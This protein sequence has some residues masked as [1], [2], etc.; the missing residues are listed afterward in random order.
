M[1]ILILGGDGMLGH[2]LL[3]SWQERHEVRVTLRGESAAYH[4][5][6][7]FDE[8]N[9]CFGVDVRDIASVEEALK[10]FA[11]EVVVN[12]VGIVK[13]RSEAADAVLSIEVNALFPHRLAQLCEAHR[14]RL[15]HMSTDCVFSGRKGMYKEGDL[16]DARDLYG[17]SKLLGELHYSHTLTLRTSIIG[18][19]LARKKSLIE[20]F[21]AQHGTVK[22]FARAIYSGFTTL[23]MARIIERLLL[24]W[25]GMNGLWHVA[26]QPISKYDLLVGLQRRLQLPVRVERDETFVCDRSLDAGRFN[27]HVG[28]EPPSWDAMLD[29]L[30]RQIEER[31][32]DS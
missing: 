7:L 21:L 4:G 32:H 1:R 26:S 28:Y 2:Q 10:A 23:E 5:Y 8:R 17:R 18:L 9:S 14:C 3:Q 24:E 19:E 30:A 31:A 29:E 27:A 12:A 22:G 6:R 11:P 13:Q 15:V 16:E 25:P 20:W